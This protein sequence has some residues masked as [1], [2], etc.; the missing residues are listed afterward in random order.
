VSGDF[1]EYANIVYPIRGGLQPCY[2]DILEANICVEKFLTWDVVGG[3]RN[4]LEDV[5]VYLNHVDQVSLLHC[6]HV[7]F[8][9]SESIIERELALNDLLLEV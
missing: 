4:V 1:G 6:V 5:C 8:F 7:C 9:S 3:R 2:F